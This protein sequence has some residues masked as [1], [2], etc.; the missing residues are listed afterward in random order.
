M[1][2]HYLTVAAVAAH[3]GLT[4]PP[5]LAL[6]HSGEIPA[7]NVSSGTQRPRWRVDP[8]DLALWLTSR[9]A[10]PQARPTPRIT[11]RRRTAAITEYV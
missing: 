4:A 10:R 9:Q 6:I 2:K 1:S 7:S 5:V 3:I 8:D 11:R